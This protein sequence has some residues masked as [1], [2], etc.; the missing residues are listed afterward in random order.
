MI[1][2]KNDKNEDSLYIHIYIDR[3]FILFYF[4][5]QIILRYLMSYFKK[6]KCKNKKKLYDLWQGKKIFI[7][8]FLGKTEISGIPQRVHCVFPHINKHNTI[9]II[10]LHFYFITSKEKSKMQNF[11]SKKQKQKE[12]VSLRSVISVKLNPFQ[13]DD[14]SDICVYT[15]RIIYVLIGTSAHLCACDNGITYILDVR[16]QEHRTTEFL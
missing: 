11:L 15:S 6:C 5:L 8:W 16:M 14:S 13:I 1:R 2:G 3:V 9:L 12:T 10:F 7:F 4:F